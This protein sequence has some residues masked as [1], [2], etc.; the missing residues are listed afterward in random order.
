MALVKYNQKR[1]FDKT[2]EPTGKLKHTKSKKLSFVIQKHQASHLHYDF[3]LE[4]D[5]VL[6][7]WAVPKGPSTNPSDKRLAMMVEDHPYEYRKFEGTIPKN[8]YGAG[9]VI[10]WDQGTYEAKG[11]AGDQE[12]MLL[13]E[14]RS[15]HITF[16]L[17]GQKLKGEYAL[18]K[19]GGPN[20]NAWLLVKK[21]DEFASKNDITG[22]DASVVT[23]RRLAGGDEI[24]SVPGPVVEMLESVS[25]MLATLTDEAFDDPNWLFE[26][27]WDGYRAIASW[28]GRVASLYSRNGSDFS[29]YKSV[30]EAL[31]N[32]KHKAV[33]D[34]EIVAIDEEGHSNFGWLQNYLSS[35][36]GQLA[37]YVFDILWLDGHDL[38]GLPLLERKQVLSKVLTGNNSV[39]R[40]SDHIIGRGR[41]FFETARTR[42]LEGIMAKQKSSLYH[43]AQRSKM[44]LKIKTHHRQEAVIGGFTEP[45]GSRKYIGALILGVY[46]NSQLVYVGHSGSGIPSSQ[47]K[48][49][50][51]QLEKIE[52]DESPFSEKVKP[53]APVHWTKPNLVCEVK[54]SEWTV[55]GIMRQPIFVGL[56]QDK[57]ARQVGREREVSMTN[58]DKKTTNKK[59]ELTHLDKVFFPAAGYTKGDL[60]DYYRSVGPLI[61]K[62]I[63]SRPHSLLRQPNGLAGQAFFQ[64]DIPKT[65]NWI[66][67]KK[68]YSESNEKDINYLVCDSLDSLLYMVQLGCIEINPWNSRVSALEKPDW[69]VIDLDPEK[70]DFAEVVKAAQIVHQICEQLDITAIPKTS[71]KTGIHIFIPLAAK[72]DYEQS[73]QFAH[74]LASLVND[75]LPD[76]TSLE[77]SPASRQ[78]KIYVDYLQNRE[79]QTLAAPYS[80]RPT[81]VA[82][83]STPLKWDEVNDKLDPNEFTIKNIGQR[84]ERV[85]DLW[86]PVVGRGIDLAKVLKKLEQL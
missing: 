78:G 1:S 63:D 56:R 25:P 19:K 43:Q 35:P 27:K 18:I 77:R 86:Q 14:L 10:I 85:G 66:K 5:G 60:I 67:T 13:R 47:I 20:D 72:Y 74:I 82:S 55:D 9:E 62:Y 30:K 32:L 49:L 81:P 75:R 54:F 21:N 40:Y 42:R 23:G 37:Y 70:I 11:S 34:G 29:K 57:P 28:D 33:L 6:K 71:G 31:R 51:Q 65:P 61:L 4:M 52:I 76:T 84:I 26:I 15:G 83:V 39:I 53:N 46:E 80:V 2:P 12:K 22:Q 59:L 45:K 38:T 44:W 79:G 64:K 73:K 16:I 48:N 7:S 17:H 69:C 68:I 8:N 24:N 36:R 3:R 50:R 41:A 58:D